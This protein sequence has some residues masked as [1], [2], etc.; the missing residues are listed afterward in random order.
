MT[1]WIVCCA[2]P[3]VNTIPHLGTFI[4]LLSADVF[5]KFLK[6]KGEEVISVTGSDE[7]GTPIEIEAIKKGVN[8]RE[9][10]DQY[11]S[12]ITHLLKEYGIEFSN[13]TRTENPITK[14]C[15]E[16]KKAS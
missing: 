6:M 3:Y 7:H 10:T 2:W 12:I 15:R 11:H 5:T 13:Y 4:H 16:P 14:H 1:K 9:I 8:P